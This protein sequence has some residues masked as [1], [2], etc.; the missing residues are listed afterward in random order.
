[1][2]RARTSIFSFYTA[3]AHVY[4]FFWGRSY[5]PAKNKGAIKGFSGATGLLAQRQA[6]R[7]VTLKKKTQAYPAQ[8]ESTCFFNRN[9]NLLVSSKR[10]LLL[11]VGV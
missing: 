1:M 11:F 9:L 6:I 10:K 5:T 8:S 4:L 2:L 7:G 3:S